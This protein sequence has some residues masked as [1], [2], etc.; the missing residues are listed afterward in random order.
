[1]VGLYQINAV[2]PAGMRDTPQAALVI[3]QG[4]TSATF[5]VRVVSP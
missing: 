4:A 2:V 1:M 3:Q 5:T